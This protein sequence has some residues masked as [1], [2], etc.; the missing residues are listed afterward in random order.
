ME[1]LKQHPHEHIMYSKNIIF[2]LNEG[3]H[4][5]FFKA[6]SAYIFKNTGIIQLPSHILW[7]RSCKIYHRQALIHLNISPLQWHRNRLLYQETI[8]DILK[9][10]QCRKI[11]TITGVL[12]KNWV[13]KFYISIGYP[14]GYPSKLYE[15]NQATIK[16]LLKDIITVQDRPLEFL[17]TTIH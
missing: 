11:T 3:P 13:I 6:C 12:Y 9:H 15:N 8:R 16:R 5:C 17:I 14:I 10:L 1:Y 7:G 4:Q 2:R